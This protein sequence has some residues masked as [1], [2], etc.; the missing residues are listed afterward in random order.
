MN[1]SLQRVSVLLIAVFALVAGFA[2]ASRPQRDGVRAVPTEP[3]LA[4]SV[5]SVAEEAE[6]RRLSLV[7]GADVISTTI[8]TRVDESVIV[9]EVTVVDV[10]SA[11]WNTGDAAMPPGGYDID[12]DES[13]VYQ[14]VILQLDRVFKTDDA[15]LT[16]VVTLEWGGVI[17]LTL[18][19]LGRLYGFAPGDQGLVMLTD[20]EV[21]EGQPYELHLAERALALS[22]SGE[23]LA[24][25]TVYDW[26]RY[27]GGTAHG[28]FYEDVLDVTDLVERVEA[29]VAP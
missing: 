13:I 3:E 10:E 8:A 7:D 26:Y 11:R 17:D 19:S 23:A 16:G 1:T 27:D 6:L 29:A 24:F 20:L 25:K 15:S 2:L 22:G 4:N 21:V 18:F 14:P 9:A 28:H 12:E 5:G